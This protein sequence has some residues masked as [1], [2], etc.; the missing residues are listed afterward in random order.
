MIR[1]II[2]SLIFCSGYQFA[3]AHYWIASFLLLAALLIG[4]A[5]K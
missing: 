3:C 5:R 1:L 2:H 4:G